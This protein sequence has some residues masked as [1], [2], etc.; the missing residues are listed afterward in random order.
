M[1]RRNSLT[2]PS[3]LRVRVGC[4]FD[5]IN[6]NTFIAAGEE[7]FTYLVQL[8]GLTPTSRVLDVGCGC[9]QLAAP[10][11]GFLQENGSYDG[12]DIDKQAIDWCKRQIAGKHP[13]FRFTLANVANAYYHRTGEQSSQHYRFPY[14][15]N[16]FDLVFLKSLFTH[17][18]GPETRAYLSEIARVLKPNAKCFITYYILNDE[19]RRLIK[20]GSSILDFQHQ[21]DGCY[22]IDPKV[23]EYTL[24]F[25][26]KV[27]RS[28]YQENNLTIEEPIHF[29]SWPG[30]ED[31]LS[32]QDIVIATKT[33]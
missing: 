5:F 28:F 2:P 8:G 20:N 16:S 3:K 23:P 24:S 6:A 12:L 30:R 32:F 22:T 26:E 15:D 21:A 14:E 29:G 17:M 11:T 33:P 25:D 4:F 1:G 27:L 13:N 9:G 31:A 10:L 19:S 7:F 18:I